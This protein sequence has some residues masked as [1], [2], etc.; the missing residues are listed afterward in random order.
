MGVSGVVSLEVSGGCVVVQGVKYFL[1]SKSP[2][3]HESSS[4]ETK[5][6]A[7]LE[8][9]ERHFRASQYTMG[10]DSSRRTDQSEWMQCGP[11]E[12]ISV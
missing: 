8:K 1:S 6:K 3:G 4:K 7:K 11:T 5:G 12:T 2:H 9:V 10:P